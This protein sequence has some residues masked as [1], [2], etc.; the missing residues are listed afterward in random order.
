M[1]RHASL[2]PFLSGSAAA[3]LWASTTLAGVLFPALSAAGLTGFRLGLGGLALAC[4]LGIPRLVQALRAAPWLLGPTLALGIGLF[5]WGYFEAAQ[6]GGGLWATWITVALTVW[7]T[8]CSPSRVF[9]ARSALLVVGLCL[10]GPTPPVAA[11]VAAAV[12]ALAY[13]GY[14]VCLAR[15]QDAQACSALALLGGSLPLIPDSLAALIRPTGR[16]GVA[17]LLLACYLGL[18]TTALAY[19]L[20]TRAVTEGSPTIALSALVLQPL[21][22]ILLDTLAGMLPPN[23]PAMLSGSLL[24]TLFIVWPNLAGR[25]S[26]PFNRSPHEPDPPSPCPQARPGAYRCAK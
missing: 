17:V 19:A 15:Q 10:L 24:L 4:W 13:A 8:A 9:A 26:Q 12:S 23:P 5:Q 3:L 21:F 7:M 22:V 11:W 1:S 20:F 6:Q 14:T 25:F 16:D 2:K 18:I